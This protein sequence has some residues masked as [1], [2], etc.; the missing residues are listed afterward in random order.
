MSRRSI[1]AALFGLVSAIIAMPPAAGAVETATATVVLGSSGL[2]LPRFVSLK[3]G[4]V[5]SRIGPGLN[6]GVDW[7]YLKPGLPMEIVQEYDNWRRVRDSD[8]AEGWINQSLLSGRRTA[9]AAPWQKGKETELT[10][11]AEPAAGLRW[12]GRYHRDALADVPP[13]MRQSRPAQG[14]PPPHPTRTARCPDTS[15]APRRLLPIRP[16]PNPPRGT[17]GDQPSARAESRAR[18]AEPRHQRVPEQSNCNWQ[19]PDSAAMNKASTAKKRGFGRGDSSQR[20]LCIESDA[21][22]GEQL[23]VMCVAMHPRGKG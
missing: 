2:P 21:G 22:R 18:A 20:R 4:R 1:R 3:S 11:H 13:A 17:A 23:H 10:L 14:T 16:S 15:P 6:Y 7:M 12:P 8:G 5:N 9:I 19:Y